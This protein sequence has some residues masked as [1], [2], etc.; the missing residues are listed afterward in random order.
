M[1]TSNKWKK[2]N[3]RFKIATIQY[4]LFGKPPKTI[5]DL[6]IYIGTKS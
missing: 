6:L 1:K 3:K 2:L 4:L 5:G